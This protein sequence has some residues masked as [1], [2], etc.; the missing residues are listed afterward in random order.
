MKFVGAGLW[1]VQAT[2]TLLG[3]TSGKAL[4]SKIG[5]WEL[6]SSLSVFKNVDT[7]FPPT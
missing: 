3:V 2:F 1:N 6:D 4:L 5:G 7:T